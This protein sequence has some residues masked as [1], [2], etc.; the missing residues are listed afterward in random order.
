MRVLSFSYCFPNQA[1]PTWGVFVAQRLE[2]LARRVELQVVSPMPVCPPLTSFRPSP[3]P[4]RDTWRGLKVYRPRFWYVP[5]LFKSA[6]ARLYAR[7]LR[8]WLRRLVAEWRPDM[9][10]AHFIWPDGVAVGLLAR[11]L[12]VPYTI[13]LRGGV[14]VYLKRPRIRPQCVEALNGARHVISLSDSMADACRQ[15]G[16]TRPRYHTVPNGVNREMFHAGSRSEAR[17]ALGLPRDLPLVVCVAYLEERKGILELIHALAQLPEQVRLV[18][19][20]SKAPD[21]PRYYDG[22]MRAIADLGIDQRVM[23]MGQQPHDRIPLYFRAA[24]VSVLASYWEGSPN[25]VVESLGCG[26]PVVATPVGSVPEQVHDGYNGYVVPMKD[27]DALAKALGEALHRKWDADAL[28]SSVMSWDQV[29]GK[30][31]AVFH[32][33]SAPTPGV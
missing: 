27:P 4:V 24:N 16:A 21:E 3:G 9:L 2:A 14:W 23:F 28:S 1:Q 29:A 20:G 17:E 10:D 15:S 5:K 33:I 19:V 6:D 22:L 26:T 18:L 11:E 7:G 32:R 13:T 25:A 31:D 30:V 8:R 12:G